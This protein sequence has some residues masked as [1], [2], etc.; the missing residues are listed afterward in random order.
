MNEP[1]LRRERGGRLRALKGTVRLREADVNLGRLKSRARRSFLPPEW[2][3][4]DI[5]MW[6]GVGHTKQNQKTE[7]RK[8]SMESGEVELLRGEKVGH[9]SCL[10]KR[11]STSRACA[12]RRGASTLSSVATATR[13]AER[14]LLLLFHF[15]DCGVMVSTLKKIKVE[16]S[17]IVLLWRSFP[18]FISLLTSVNI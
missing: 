7:G 10:R 16:D 12:V 4:F 17:E 8:G 15:F 14:K 18:C 5:Y 6:G 3:R 13:L 2:F 11:V 1:V 9:T